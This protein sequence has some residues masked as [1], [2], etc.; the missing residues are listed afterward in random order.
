[1]K[2]SL[3]RGLLAFFIL[4]TVGL[5]VSAR[6]NKTL[7]FKLVNKTGVDIYK[8]FISQADDDEW[9]DDVLDIDVLEDGDEVELE[10]DVTEKAKHWDLK[11]EDEEETAIVWKRLDLSKIN[12][13]T[14][15]IVGGKPI[16]E[17][18]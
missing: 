6:Q 10:F 1:M 8:I 9:G 5:G 17:I 12:V 11:V 16:A 15:K 2:R 13:L 7:D 4:M 3:T 14:L 18:K